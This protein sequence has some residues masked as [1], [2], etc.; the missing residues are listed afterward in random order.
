M[1][2][3]DKQDSPDKTDKPTPPAPAKATHVAIPMVFFQELTQ[4][5]AGYPFKEV[6]GILTRLQSTGKPLLIKD[7]EP[8]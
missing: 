7:E 2:D 6:A 3:T 1:N 4:F 8:K 5:L